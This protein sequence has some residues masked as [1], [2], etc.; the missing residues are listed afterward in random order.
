MPGTDSDSGSSSE[1]EAEYLK[2]RE[3]RIAS[4]KDELL[5]LGLGPKDQKPKKDSRKKKKDK[6]ST[7]AMAVPQRN[8]GRTGISQRPWG[9]LMK[10]AQKAEGSPMATE[11]LK[12]S[13]KRHHA[14][15]SISLT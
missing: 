4:N 5:E 3:A 2:Q 10:H 6:A 7:E 14:Q 13:R 11:R 1:S 8:D 12:P 9:L 15:A